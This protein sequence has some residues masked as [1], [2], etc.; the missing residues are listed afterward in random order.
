MQPSEEV[1]ASTAC[2]CGN[3]DTLAAVQQLRGCLELFRM[4]HGSMVHVPKNSLLSPELLLKKRIAADAETIQSEGI[5]NSP[6]VRFLAR[7]SV[8][9]PFALSTAE[10]DGAGVEWR[11]KLASPEVV[12]GA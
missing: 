5:G 9:R 1:G 4:K 6:N 2:W 12:G 11:H 3:D 8:V 10:I 7:V